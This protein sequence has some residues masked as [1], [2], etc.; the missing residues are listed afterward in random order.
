MRTVLAID[1]RLS[2]IFLIHLLRLFL[3]IYSLHC[4]IKT[5][6]T[7]MVIGSNKHA[8]HDEFKGRKG[9]SFLKNEGKKN[10]LQSLA[11]PQP[12]KQSDLHLCCV[13]AETNIVLTLHDLNLF[14]Q[15]R[16][17]KP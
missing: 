10:D 6:Y 11:M 5:G 15:K 2:T 17:E 7:V 1:L 12:K 14:C 9:R 16:Y 3:F 8:I 13:I 4:E